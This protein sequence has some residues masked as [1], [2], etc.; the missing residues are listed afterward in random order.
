M[1]CEVSLSHRL[2]LSWAERQ[3]GPRCSI[4]PASLTTYP[5]GGGWGTTSGQREG[6][7]DQGCFKPWEIFLKSLSYFEGPSGGLA[8]VS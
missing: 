2:N 5:V 6:D 7:A 3:V 8:G 1:I 4:Q